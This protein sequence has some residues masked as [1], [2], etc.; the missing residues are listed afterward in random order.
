MTVLF[1][2]RQGLERRI[3]KAA[4]ADPAFRQ[5]LLDDPKAALADLLGIS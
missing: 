1:E 5:R 3:A 2:S 4:G